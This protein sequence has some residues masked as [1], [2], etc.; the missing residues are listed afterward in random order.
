MVIAQQ[1]IANTLLHYFFSKKAVFKQFFK[2]QKYCTIA[3]F[4]QMVCAIVF[5]I[6]LGFLGAFFSAFFPIQSFIN[7]VFDKLKVQLKFVSFSFMTY[8]RCNSW[9]RLNSSKRFDN[10]F[11]NLGQILSVLPLFHKYFYCTIFF[12]FQ[13]FV[14][15]QQHYSSRQRIWN[16]SK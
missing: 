5:A 16:G 10:L 9:S 3:I 11:S 8:F 2:Q 13:A 15:W 14:Q 1:T 4:F 7:F 6:V 12:C